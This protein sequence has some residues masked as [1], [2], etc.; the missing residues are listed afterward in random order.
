MTRMANSRSLK[1]R[2]VVKTRNNPKLI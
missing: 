1:I 2:L